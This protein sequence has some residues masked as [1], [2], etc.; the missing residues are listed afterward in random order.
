MLLADAPVKAPRVRKEKEPFSIDF[1]TPLSPEQLKKLFEPH[2]KG[3]N[4]LT[5]P[6][7]HCAYIG[8]NKGKKHAGQVREEKLLPEDMHFSAKQLTS[9]FLK[10]KFGVRTGCARPKESIAYVF[11]TVELVG[12]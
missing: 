7:K 6:A 2:P 9:L 10:P 12:A 1:S 5:L 3:N 8:G 11:T 4:A